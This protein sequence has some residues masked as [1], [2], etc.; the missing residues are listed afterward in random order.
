MRRM[1]CCLR[2]TQGR[3]GE[4]ATDKERAFERS[5]RTPSQTISLNLTLE[6]A[7]DLQIRFGEFTAVNG[8]NPYRSIYAHRE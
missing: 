7:Q 5:V 1:G 8:C 2:L 6:V 3:P 4:D